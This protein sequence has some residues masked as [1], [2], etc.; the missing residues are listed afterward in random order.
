VQRI[1]SRGCTELR[2]GHQDGSARQIHL[3]EQ[4]MEIFASLG[5]CLILVVGSAWW[6]FRK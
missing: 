2:F 5:G 6:I 1:A 3:G 4:G